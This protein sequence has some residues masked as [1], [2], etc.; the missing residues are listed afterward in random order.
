M[1]ET[2]ALDTWT[3]PHDTALKARAVSALESGAVLFFPN[4]PFL[5]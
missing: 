5:L 2:L 1:L 3:G 4:L